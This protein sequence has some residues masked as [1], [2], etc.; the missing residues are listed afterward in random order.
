MLS[1]RDAVYDKARCRMASTGV[2]SF[3]VLWVLYTC[4]NFSG[5]VHGRCIYCSTILDTCYSLGGN[6]KTYSHSYLGPSQNLRVA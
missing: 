5:Q 4:M 6:R 2:K 3:F 1:G